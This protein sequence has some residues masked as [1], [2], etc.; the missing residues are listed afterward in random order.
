MYEGWDG[1]DENRSRLVNKTV[2]AGMDSSREF[3]A[4]REAVIEKRY[5]VDEIGQR[6]L[7]GDGGSWI[8]EPYDPE[9][10]FQLDRYHICQ[11]IVRKISDKEARK[12][13]R[14]LFDEEKMEEMLDYIQTYATSVASPDKQDKSSKKA[15]ELYTYL[16]NNR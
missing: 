4:K 2:L 15:L 10:I 1:T 14:R 13:V 11:E 12:E 8:R 3:H 16:N 9:T 5:D 7:N 6:V